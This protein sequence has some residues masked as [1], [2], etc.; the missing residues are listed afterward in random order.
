LGSSAS[1]RGMRSKPSRNRIWCTGP[2][3]WPL[4]A[5]IVTISRKSINWPKIQC[6]SFRLAKFNHWTVCFLQ[7]R[8][9]CR[10][11]DLVV[12]TC[13]TGSQHRLHWHPSTYVYS[14]AQLS[15]SGVQMYLSNCLLTSLVRTKTR[16][17]SLAK[18]ENSSSTRVSHFQTEA[19]TTSSPVCCSII[20]WYNYTV[21]HKNRAT[22]SFTI[23]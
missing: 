15:I 20:Q 3:I 22:S 21:G 17:G 7:S 4:M 13:L 18:M 9:R 10:Q 14:N 12:Q 11:L 16:C 5:T 8:R 6:G 23:T 19:L 2:K 1:Q